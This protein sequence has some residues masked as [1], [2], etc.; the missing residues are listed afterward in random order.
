[1]NN[2]ITLVQRV[3]RYGAERH[4]RTGVGTLAVFGGHMDW[5]LRDRFPLVTAKET[6]W[7]TAFIEMLWFLRG[8]G[9]THFLRKHNCKLWDAWADAHGNLG[10]V[11]GMQWRGRD[12][13]SGGVDQV[14][15][16]I[17]SINNNPHGRRHIVSAWSV[18]DLPNMALPPCHAWHQLYADGEDWLDMQVYQRSWD[19]ALGAPFNIAQYALLLELYARATGRL[20]RRLSFCYGDA[21]IYLDHAQA[22]RTVV[23]EGPVYDDRAT[24]LIHTNN[25]DIDGYKI[26]DFEIVGYQPKKFVR[27]GVAV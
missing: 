18:E 2:Y 13:C 17:E 23:E 4:D 9:H 15:T 1:M 14:A 20:A 7:R 19:L 10:P 24:L 16:V 5:D 12:G 25:T 11:Y 3:L 6:R 27:L 8:E 26:E 21:H 22:M